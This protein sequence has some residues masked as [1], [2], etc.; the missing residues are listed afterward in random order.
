[1]TRIIP[2]TKQILT[3][4]RGS[5]AIIVG[6]SMFVLLGFAA[7]A[8]DFGYSY[9]V[10]NELQNAADAA[11]LAGASVLFRSNTLCLAFDRPYD[12][13][14]GNKTGSCDQ[15]AIDGANVIATAQAVATKNLSGGAQVPVPIVEV[16]HYAF[17]SSQSNPGDFTPNPTSTQ[18]TGW[19]TQ[20]FSDLNTNTNFI[21]A[22][23]VTASRT[24]VP[25]F[26]SRIWG[27][28]DLAITVQATAYVGFAGTL[29]P[30]EVDQP[31]AVCEQSIKDGNRY[32]CNVGTMLN[33]N[34]Q[35][36]RWTNFEQ[37][38]GCGTANNSEI[39]P[40]ICAGGNP[41]AIILGEGIG[42][43]NGTI[44]NEVTSIYDCWKNAQYDTN[45][46]GIPDAPVDTDGDGKP[47]KPWKLTIPV[48]DC[49]CDTVYPPGTTPNCTPTTNCKKVTGAAVVNVVWINDKNSTG[50]DKADAWIPKSMTVGDKTWSQATNC[51]GGD[52]TTC[53]NSFRQ[54]FNLQNNNLTGAAEWEQKA[55]YFLPD[56]E[57]HEPSGTTGGENYGILAR[58]PVLVNAIREPVGQ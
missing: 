18:L 11:A 12:C 28:S 5:V 48:I 32:T 43:T 44:G 53:W 20:L 46:D 33:N 22:V 13:C 50:L 31:I 2:S 30:S 8:I 25:R 17:A 49:N 45:G 36:S 41:V 38:A 55:L 6:L 14:T 15:A 35:T 39:R 57:V 42:T 1:M 23:R 9:V 40:L 37:G 21:N 58:Y 52:A 51:P 56:C 54:K 27:D 29:V 47:D 16:G 3:G 4:R 24:D 34:T 19:Q 10:T 7:F 26:F